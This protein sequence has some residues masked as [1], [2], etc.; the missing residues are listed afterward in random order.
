MIFPKHKAGMYIEHNPHKDFYQ[1]VTEY[2]KE[3]ECEED[4]VSEY[5]IYKCI[6][7]NEL[8]R[9]QWYPDTPIGSYSVIGHSLES[10]L[11]EAN[12]Y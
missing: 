4:F 8:W 3:N 2:I 9:I 5:D 12:S 1:T 6:E 10:I 11:E 7:N